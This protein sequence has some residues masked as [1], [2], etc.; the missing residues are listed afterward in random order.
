MDMQEQVPGLE[1]GMPSP[2]EAGPNW[3]D[4]YGEMMSDHAGTLDELMQQTYAD[5]S[6]AGRRAAEMNAA[7]GRGVSGGGF[8]SGQAQVAMGGMNARQ[9]AKLQHAQKGI[10]LKMAYLDRLYQQ[11]EKDKDRALQRELQEKMDAAMKDSAYI[12]AVLGADAD[13]LS[14]LQTGELPGYGDGDGDGGGGGGGGFWS[15]LSDTD[16]AMT[17]GSVIGGPYVAI[18]QGVKKG[19]DWLFGG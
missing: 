6:R 18:G 8:A 3:D 19:Y 2:E 9:Q 15:D 13:T 16:K 11:A 12:S 1:A 14:Y 10:E 7:M 17:V 4:I 5:E